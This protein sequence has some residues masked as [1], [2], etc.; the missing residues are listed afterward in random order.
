MRLSNI[1]L[2]LETT[3]PCEYPIYAIKG[4]AINQTIFF[5][6]EWCWFGIP[7]SYSVKQCMRLA[8]MQLSRVIC[9]VLCD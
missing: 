5:S 7:E 6:Y 4:Y 9:N 8:N 3:S 1:S 2:K